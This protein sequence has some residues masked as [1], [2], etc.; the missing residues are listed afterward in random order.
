LTLSAKK[1]G[2]NTGEKIFTSIEFDFLQVQL[3]F[4][5]RIWP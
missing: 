4:A 3:K 2:T 1:K 5:F